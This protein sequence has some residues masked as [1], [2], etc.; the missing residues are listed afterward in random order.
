ML[1]LHFAL[2]C[3]SNMLKYYRKMIFILY[4]H[5]T[6]DYLL[7]ERPCHVCT[8]YIGEHEPKLVLWTSSAVSQLLCPFYL[9][10]MGVMSNPSHVNLHHF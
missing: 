9:K 10:K 8:V 3:V 4:D 6:K 7:L 1:R 2:T 5:I